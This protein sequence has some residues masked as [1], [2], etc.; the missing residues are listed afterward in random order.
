MNRKTPIHPLLHLNI[1]VHFYLSQS[2]DYLT[3]YKQFGHN[4]PFEKLN[5]YK[6]QTPASQDKPH[7]IYL[8]E[9]D[10]LKK[11]LLYLHI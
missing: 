5:F 3:N 10:D 7:I 8:L 4:I 6:L 1:N 11:L 2:K 9:R